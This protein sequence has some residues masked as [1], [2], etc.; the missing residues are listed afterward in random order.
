MPEFLA[1]Y[2]PDAVAEITGI[3]EA[4]IRAGR[5]SGSARPATG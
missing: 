1:D 4:D 2:P 3:P 5:A